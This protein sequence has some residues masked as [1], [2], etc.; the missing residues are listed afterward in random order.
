ME[1]GRDSSE[2]SSIGS[3]FTVSR[4]I[5]RQVAAG[6]RTGSVFRGTRVNFWIAWPSFLAAVLFEK[7][8]TR[9]YCS[10][11]H[12]YRST[13]MPRTFRGLSALRECAMGHRLT[14]RYSCHGVREQ[15]R[16][17]DDERLPETRNTESSAT[18]SRSGEVELWVAKRGRLA[19][20]AATDAHILNPSY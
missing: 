8:S 18:V 10:R 5:H 20:F 4:A 15:K 16:R 14:S 13:E 12:A 19:H 17:Q 1:S 6:T 11:V 2:E 9:Q 7:H 3:S